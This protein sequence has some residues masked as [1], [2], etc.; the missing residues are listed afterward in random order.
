MESLVPENH[1]ATEEVPPVEALLAA[2]SDEAR[3]VVEVTYGVE[4]ENLHMGSPPNKE[5]VAD[6]VSAIQGIVT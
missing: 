5:I 6:I 4:L 1:S 3:R 2:A